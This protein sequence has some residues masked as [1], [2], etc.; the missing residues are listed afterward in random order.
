MVKWVGATLLPALIDG[1]MGIQGIRQTDFFK[2]VSSAEGLSQ[3]G[4]RPEDAEDLIDAYRQS[5]IG[6]F[7]LSS[8]S[9]SLEFGDES[10]LRLGTPHF[11]AGTGHLT[12]SSW[13]EFVL[14][15]VDAPSHGF[16]ERSRIP[17]K[18]QDRIRLTSPF[19]GLMLKEGVFGS[20]GSWDFP[21]E[22]KR[23]I[24][25]WGDRNI[26]HIEDA[27]LAETFRLLTEAF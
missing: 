4:I 1:G 7:S 3:L 5:F 18:A 13:M 17:Q 20:V 24:E 22:A 11:A 12:V 19:G 9:L 26:P 15:D 23:D 6:K 27:L 21:A 25:G 8:G 14:D 10:V 16:V 2:F